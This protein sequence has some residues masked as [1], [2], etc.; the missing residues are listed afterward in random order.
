MEEK[1]SPRIGLV[2]DPSPIKSPSKPASQDRVSACLVEPEPEPES[3]PE[4]EAEPEQP[5]LSSYEQR[6]LERKKKREMSGRCTDEEV[7]SPAIT[8]KYSNSRSR[9]ENGETSSM[10]SAKDS[11]LKTAGVN[12]KPIS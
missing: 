9:R 4:P 10:K 3:K 7:P 5:K 2:E 1:D 11:Y 8:Q 12:D 6:R